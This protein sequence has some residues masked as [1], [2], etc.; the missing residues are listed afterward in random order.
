MFI[1]DL[2]FDSGSAFEN[3]MLAYAKDPVGHVVLLAQRLRLKPIL[4]GN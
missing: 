3:Q 4:Y 1:M 2:Y